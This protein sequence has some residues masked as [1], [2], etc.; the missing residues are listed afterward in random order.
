MKVRPISIQK[1]RSDTVQVLKIIG[2]FDN[3]DP[4][5]FSG[6]IVIPPLGVIALK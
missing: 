4:S 1:S 5:D 6:L 2:G 3:I